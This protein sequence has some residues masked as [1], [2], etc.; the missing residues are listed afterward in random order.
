[1]LHP[2]GLIIIVRWLALVV[3]FLDGTLVAFILCR[4]AARNRFYRLQDAAQVRFSKVAAKYLTGTLP[5]RD[6]ITSLHLDGRADQEAAEK[7]LLAAIDTKTRDAITQLLFAIGFVKQWSQT[8]FALS[9]E[10]FSLI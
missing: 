1:V 4:R 2:P 3:L 8:A 9:K 5:L 6:T 10:S 7:V